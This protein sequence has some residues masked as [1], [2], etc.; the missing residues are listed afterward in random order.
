MERVYV[1]F[2]PKFRSIRLPC[3]QPSRINWA[4]CQKSPQTQ[5][6]KSIS[7]QVLQLKGKWSNKKAQEEREGPYMFYFF[8]RR[9]E[10]WYNILQAKETE[11]VQAVFKGLMI[12]VLSVTSSG[13][14]FRRK[15]S[16]RPYILGPFLFWSL[17]FY[18]TTFS[19]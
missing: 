9:R 6:W 17:H 7:C 15:Y 8:F 12:D 4:H 3:F 11:R 16:F 18:F 13:F 14:Y 2:T 5:I 10:R 19:P 1:S